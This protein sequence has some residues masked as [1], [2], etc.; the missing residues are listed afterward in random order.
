[1]LSKK[2]RLLKDRDFKKIYKSAPKI[3]GDFLSIRYLANKRDQSRFGLVVS[4]QTI[5]KATKRNLVKR[6]LREA[7]GGYLDRIKSGYDVILKFER[8]PRGT[9]LE[10]LKEK[11]FSFE[12]ERLFGHTNLFK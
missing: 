10:E 8:V 4:N 1:M 2:Y 7:L 11:D 3:R 5:T 6:R 12:L 9:K